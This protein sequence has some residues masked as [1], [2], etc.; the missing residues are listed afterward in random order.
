MSS[1][2]PIHADDEARIADEMARELDAVAEATRATP[3]VGFAD[4]VMA[5]VAGEPLPQP[6]RAFG[7]AVA[8]RRLGAA[9]ASIGDAWRV[10][11]GG[12][13]PMA[14]RAQA[15][16]LVLVVAAGSLAVAGGATVGAIDLF[17]A[18]QP[19]QPSPTTPRPTELLPSPSPTS[20]PQPAARIIG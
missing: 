15:L 8:T 5:S 6:A 10:A 4:R 12:P 3:P 18:N 17:N 19:P 1:Q 11:L 13:A 2:L 7:A 9:L 20:E 14:V 16:A